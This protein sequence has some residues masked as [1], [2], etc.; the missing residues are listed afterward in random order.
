MT[1]NCDSLERR[2]FLANILKEKTTLKLFIIKRFQTE[3]YDRH[4]DAVF[5]KILLIVPQ[6]SLGPRHHKHLHR[7]LVVSNQPGK[8]SEKDAQAKDG[9]AD[10]IMITLKSA[11][12]HAKRSEER[13]FCC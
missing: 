9:E 10:T 13:S 1:H 12:A 3:I 2:I 8:V 6:S 4:G 5:P 11:D 7:L